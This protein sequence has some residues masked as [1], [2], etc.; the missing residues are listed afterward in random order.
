MPGYIIC[1][2]VSVETT[3]ARTQ[4]NKDPER[5]EAGGH[6]HHACRS[7]IPEAPIGNEPATSGPAP[8][9]T[10]DPDKSTKDGYQNQPATHLD[11]LD[12]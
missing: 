11:S 7:N 3:L 1:G 5:K 8:T 4:I 2:T 9:G 10:H 6:M 12:H